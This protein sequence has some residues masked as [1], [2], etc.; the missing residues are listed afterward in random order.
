MHLPHRP[1]IALQLLIQ[2]NLLGIIE[3]ER[4]YRLFSFDELMIDPATL[5]I[6]DEHWGMTF[7]EF[8]AKARLFDHEKS[9]TILLYYPESQNQMMLKVAWRDAS[10]LSSHELSNY[11]KLFKPVQYGRVEKT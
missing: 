8:S 4:I 6:H 11:I 1:R 7:E 2:S 9:E 3:S 10:A 5:D